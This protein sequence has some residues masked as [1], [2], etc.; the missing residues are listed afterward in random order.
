MDLMSHGLAI[1][2]LVEQL[3]GLFADARASRA[4]SV[5]TLVF[6][7]AFPEWPELHAGRAGTASPLWLAEREPVGLVRSGDCTQT[8]DISSLLVEGL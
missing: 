4:E 5:E 6:A 8:V 2:R 1:C 7:R 3:R